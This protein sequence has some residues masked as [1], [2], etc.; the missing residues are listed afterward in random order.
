MNRIAAER[1]FPIP[2]T[3]GVETA[4]VGDTAD[5]PR[6]AVPG[7]RRGGRRAEHHAQRQTADH[8]V[9]RLVPPVGSAETGQPSP[10][11][12]CLCPAAEAQGAGKLSP[13]YCWCSVGYV[14]ELHERVF[15]RP[16]NVELVQSV[17]MGHPRC[18]FLI[19]LA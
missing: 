7:W 13:T 5:R 9:L 8:L 17:L 18:R 6:G 14:K 10:E 19:T 16:V 1:E 2:E 12:V 11:H 3:E 15:G 4:P